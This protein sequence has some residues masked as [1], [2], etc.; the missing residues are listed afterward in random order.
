VRL[1]QRH[2][3]DVLEGASALQHRRRCASQQHD[4]RLGDLGVLDR[5]DGVGQAWAG[6]HSRHAGPP[7]EPRR[8]VGGKDG[9][10]LVACIDHTDAT[11]LATD[12]DRRDVAAAEREQKRHALRREDAGNQVAA[13]HA[14]PPWCNCR[15]QIADCA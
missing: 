10:G 13:M 6:G 9:G 4:R 3:V 12:E 2:L 14:R 11:L 5:G 15:L 7:A 1:Q 8:C